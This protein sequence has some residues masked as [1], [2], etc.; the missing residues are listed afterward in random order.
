MKR[1]DL[2]VGQDGAGKS[3]FVAL[4]LA[5]ILRG[6]VLVNAD[7]IA[8]ARWGWDPVAHRGDA[9]DIALRTCRALTATGRSVMYET[10]FSSEADLEFLV[11][12]QAAGYL[13]V[14]HVMLVPEPLA[15]FRQLAAGRVDAGDQY[16]PRWTAMADA[17]ALSEQVTVYDNSARRGPM[18]IAAFNSGVPMGEPA[19]PSWAPAELV[20]MQ[21]G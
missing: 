2:V 9:A 15:T 19:W 8:R 16:R 10:T 12:A 5:P 13:V 17:I 7:E 21:V 6:S 4:T 1:L 18:A 11:T 3:S 14:Q 20:A